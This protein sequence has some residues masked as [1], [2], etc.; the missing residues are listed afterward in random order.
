[1]QRINQGLQIQITDEAQFVKE[2]ETERVV[3]TLL[4]K[5]AFIFDSGISHEEKIQSL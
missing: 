1:M 2:Q 5:Y 3:N 4:E